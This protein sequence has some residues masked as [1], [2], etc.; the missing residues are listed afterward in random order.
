MIAAIGLIGAFAVAANAARADTMAGANAYLDVLDMHGN[1]K[2][3]G[4]RSFNIFFDNGAWQGY[5]LPPANDAETGFVGP[6]VHSLGKGRWVGQRFAQL[7]LSPAGGQKPAIALHRLSGHS[8]PGYLVRKFTAPGLAVSETLFFA[9]SWSV[10]ARIDITADSRRS[11]AVA[12]GGRLMDAAYGTLASDGGAVVQTLP[13]SRST[14]VTRLYRAPRED[15][16]AV[17]TGL[18]YRIALDR[19]L[20]L[21]PGKTASVYVVQT[22]RVDAHSAAPPA[23]DF[24]TVWARNRARWSGYLRV[25]SRAHL[26]GLPDA[27]ARHVAVKAMETLLGN[28]RAPRGDLH[29]AGVI[30]SYSNP[31]F[32]GFWAWDSWKHAAALAAFAPGLA[33]EQMLAMFD[34]QAPD[35]MLPDCIFLDK[36]NNNWRDTKPPLAAWAAL[37]VHAATGDKA[38]LAGIYPKLVRYHDWWFTHRDHDHNGLAEY[39]STDGTAQ[40]ARW[41]SG[42]DNAVRFDHIRM[43]RN[44]SDAWSMNQESVDLNAYLYRDARDLAAIAGLLGKRDDAAQWSKRAAAMQARIRARFFDDK[45]GYFFDARLGNHEF[46][47]VYGPEGWIPL[48]AGVASQDQADA[49]ARVL[50]DPLK[51]DTFMPFPTLAADDPRFSPVRGYWRGPIWLDQAWFGIAG[52]RRYGHDRQAHRMALRLVR[53]T[54]GLTAQAPIFEN[55]D[56]LTGAGHQSRNFSWSAA[57]YLLLLLEP[58]EKP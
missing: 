22:L 32:N 44:G 13:G 38:F 25:A 34:Y 45:A 11:L 18:E 24:A 42:M 33:R 49:V 36:A 16:T 55:H 27:A 28:W 29:H 10:L 50:R 3:P 43:V 1:P 12:A 19:P 7:Q 20:R 54:R 5:S 53:N 23:I 51:F 2:S 4:D 14:L 48:W 9:D 26:T 37:K 39:G 47:S 35:G 21:E 58:Q 8:A 56:P 6:F 52:L 40:A 31:D 46:V 41:E 17:A 57:S 15:A 30:P